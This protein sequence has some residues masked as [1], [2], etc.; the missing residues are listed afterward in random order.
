MK[1]VAVKFKWPS[2]FNKSI[3]FKLVD[4]AIYNINNMSQVNGFDLVKT[5]ESLDLH[6]KSLNPNLFHAWFDTDCKDTLELLCWLCLY[7]G[8]EN[9]ISA[10]ELE[11]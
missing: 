1:F 7:I 6:T 11:E 3:I 5:F 4:L 2:L 10:T 9:I 8:E